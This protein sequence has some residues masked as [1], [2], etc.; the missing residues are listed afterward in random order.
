MIS[1][2]DVSVIIP[3][4]AEAGRRRELMRAITSVRLSSQDRIHIIVVVNGNRFDP[5]LC[6]WL[7]AQ[8]DVRYEYLEAPSLPLA[9]KRGRELVDTE[10]FSFLDDDDE[11][12][13]GATDR[14]RECLLENE[15]ADFVITNGFIHHGNGDTLL[16]TSLSDVPADPLRCL[17]RQTWLHNCN[18]LFR[19][20]SLC[21]EY[22]ADYHAYCEWTWLAYRLALDGKRIVVLDQPTF[23]YNDTQNSL[24]KSTAYVQSAIPL[25]ERMLKRDPPK[26]IGQLIRQRMGSTHH[27]LSSSA[28]DRGNWRGAW[29]SHLR[30]LSAPG[31]WRYLSYTRH[32]V[33]PLL[34]MR[35]GK[36]RGR[37][38]PDV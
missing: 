29:I 18:A 34:C 11:Y 35:S 14:K 6:R 4:L 16:Y 1:Q 12:L 28:L 23:R 5:E 21:A 30:S 13:A 37:R 7:Q 27:L 24:S 26:P 33:N 32:L 8:P 38:A 36:V 17:F 3:T 9:Q 19:S 2:G 22:L 15:D 20:R 31:G 25:C 10:F